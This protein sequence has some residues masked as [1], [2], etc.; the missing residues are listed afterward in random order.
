MHSWVRDDS[1]RWSAIDLLN[2]EED[3]SIYTAVYRD[4]TDPEKKRENHRLINHSLAAERA[5]SR[6]MCGLRKIWRR[7]SIN[8]NVR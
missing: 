7:Q 2:V 6:I 5:I 1:F 4:Y 8:R 3:E